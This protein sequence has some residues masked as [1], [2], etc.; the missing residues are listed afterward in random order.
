MCARTLT[1][2]YRSSFLISALAGLLMG[3]NARGQDFEFFERNVRPVFVEHCYKCHSAQ[4]EK[5]KGGLLLDT[6]EGLLIG[7]DSGPAILPGSP[8]KSLLIKAVRYTDKDLQMPP[9][10]KKLSDAQI[11]DLVAWVKMG[12]PD[13]RMTEARAGGT[14]AAKAKTWWAFQP[15]LKPKVPGAS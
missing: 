2:W 8:E 11:A 5:L 12:A 10:N 1:L 13:Q 3:V 15:L 7:G 4:A 14:V 6:R 9:K